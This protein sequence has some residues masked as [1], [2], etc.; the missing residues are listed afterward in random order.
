[1]IQLEREPGR[2]AR[3][4]S[5]QVRPRRQRRHLSVPCVQLGGTPTGGHVADKHQVLHLG[6]HVPPVHQLLIQG[7]CQRDIGAV[8]GRWAKP[9]ADEDAREL[10]P[11]RVV[12]D[13]SDDVSIDISHGGHQPH[14]VSDAKQAAGKP[15]GVGVNRKS[16]ED[17]V[18]DD[19]DA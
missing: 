6:T 1:M 13:R 12:A 19:D 5:D 14:R 4:V 8:I 11:G 3:T 15:V 18:S 2:H 7:A 16:C 17:L 9:S 10:S